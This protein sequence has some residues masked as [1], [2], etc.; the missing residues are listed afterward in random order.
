[1]YDK[2]LEND[3]ARMVLNEDGELY[4]PEDEEEDFWDRIENEWRRG[5]S[6]ANAYS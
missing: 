4:V 3:S 6:D 2:L 1:M 5:E